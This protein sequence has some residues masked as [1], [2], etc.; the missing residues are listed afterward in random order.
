MFEGLIQKEVDS[1]IQTTF[2]PEKVAETKAKIIARIAEERLVE[3]LVDSVIDS[4]VAGI[5]AVAS[6]ENS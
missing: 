4:A 3:N 5:L 6:K 2:T 1:Y